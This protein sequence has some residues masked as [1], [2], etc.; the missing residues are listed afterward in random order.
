MQDCRECANKELNFSHS[1]KFSLDLNAIQ[2]E[3]T[4]LK[5]L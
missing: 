2:K 5:A 1:I 3:F 4:Y